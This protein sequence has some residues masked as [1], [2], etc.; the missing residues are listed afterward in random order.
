MLRDATYIYIYIHIR[1]KMQ[2]V[3]FEVL[4]IYFSNNSD[5]TF[6]NICKTHYI[7]LKTVFVEIQNI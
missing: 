5:K 3:E 4:N 1:H 6:P 2:F 7:V